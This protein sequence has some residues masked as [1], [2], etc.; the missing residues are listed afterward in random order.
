ME[1]V[2]IILNQALRTLDSEHLVALTEALIDRCPKEWKDKNITNNTDK[3]I[4]VYDIVFCPH[5]IIIEDVFKIAIE[6]GYLIY[7]SVG[8]DG[9]KTGNKPY[10]IN[11]NDEIDKILVD[12]S[13]KEGKEIY[14]KI[15]QKQK[16]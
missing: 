2:N 14:E 15:K 3:K 1:Q 10:M 11:P 8:I 5:Y 4:I 7:E 13:T 16:Q 12:I 9:R 6:T